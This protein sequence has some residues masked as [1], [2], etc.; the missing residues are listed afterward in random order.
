MVFV[1]LRTFRWGRGRAEVERGRRPIRNLLLNLRH[2]H[3]RRDHAGPDRQSRLGPD[4]HCRSGSA[5]GPALLER[6]LLRMPDRPLKPLRRHHR[7]SDKVTLRRGS[8]RKRCL[9]HRVGGPD[10]HVLNAGGRL[11][12]LLLRLRHLLLLF[13]FLLLQQIFEQKWLFLL[14]TK[15]RL[16]KNLIFQRLRANVFFLRH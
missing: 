7:I 3:R 13:A 14:V 8:R 12:L 10:H 11:E 1:C 16:E 9:L 5:N 4:D 15:R 6:H 2:L